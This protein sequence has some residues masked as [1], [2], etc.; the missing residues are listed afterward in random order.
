[1]SHAEALQWSAYMQK[2]GGANL[3][4]RMEAGFALVA[5]AIN[6]SVGGK[7]KFDDFTPHLKEEEGTGLMDIFSKL[8]GTGG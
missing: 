2:R 6:R 5:T 7:A 1:M 3:G 8:G 4:L